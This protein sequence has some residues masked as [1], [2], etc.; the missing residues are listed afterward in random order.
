MAGAIPVLP[1]SYIGRMFDMAQKRKISVTLDEDLV[2][3]LEVEDETLSAQVNTAVRVEVERRVRQ[4]LLQR[5]LD[6]LEQADGP[7]DEALVS[8]F[9][10]RLT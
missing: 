9:E 10:E 6:E 7:I 8:L 2:S 3:A 5:W 4:Q 1:M